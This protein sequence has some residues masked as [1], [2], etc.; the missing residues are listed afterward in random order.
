MSLRL[1]SRKSKCMIS[2][3]FFI[4]SLYPAVEKEG[5]ER[6][7]ISDLVERFNHLYCGRPY[8]PIYSPA[9]TP[10]LQNVRATVFALV[11]VIFIFA[12]EK[13]D[14]MPFITS[15]CLQLLV[16]KVQC[17]FCLYWVFCVE[18]FNLQHL[19]WR[20]QFFT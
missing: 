19:Y 9:C 5:F 8:N 14:L 18:Q 11:D 4:A 12:M 6:R 1:F 2:H 16:S 13:L 17:L 15:M 10:G 7:F 20:H 3:N